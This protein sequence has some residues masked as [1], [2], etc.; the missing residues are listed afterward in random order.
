MSPVFEE[1][2]AER[3]RAALS[4]GEMT[5]LSKLTERQLSKGLATRLTGDAN[6]T[7]LLAEG[8]SMDRIAKSK[9]GQDARPV[10]AVIFDKRPGSNWALGWHQDR[11]IA[12]CERRD[13]PGFGRWSKKAGIIHVEPPFEYFE[14]MVTLRAHLDDCG[15]DNAPLEIVPGSHLRGRVILR[16]AKALVKRAGTITCEAEAGDIWVY[17]TAIVHAS[18]AAEVPK[19]RRVLHVDYSAATLPGGLEWLGL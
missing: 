12:V 13:T 19:R 4:P 1:T 17:A 9:L 6:L 15:V 5:L 3:H 10:R 7:K 2:G 8:G 16:D 14:N 11:T 18:K